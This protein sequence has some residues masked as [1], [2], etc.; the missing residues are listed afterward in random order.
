MKSSLW[1]FIWT[2]SIWILSPACVMAAVRPIE[3]SESQTRT[4]LAAQL[5]TPSELEFLTQAE[6]VRVA[7]V[8]HPKIHQAQARLDQAR[9]RLSEARRWFRPRIAVYAGERLDTQGH[10]AG[11]QIS[12][13]LDNLWNRSKIHDAEAELVVSEQDLFLTRQA[14]VEETVSAYNAWTLARGE[15]KRIA[16]RIGSVRRALRHAHEQYEEGLISRAQLT[17]LEQKLD[18][19]Q[20]AQEESSARLVQS[21]VRLRQAMGELGV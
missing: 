7:L 16:R 3:P 4:E 20:Q 2:V 5:G 9:A 14:V 6:A 8:H 10:R 12:H 15:C 1:L 13:D 17:E 18:T 21:A 11:I 19:A